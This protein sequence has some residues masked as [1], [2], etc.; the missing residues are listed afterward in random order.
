MAAFHQLIDTLPGSTQRI[1][2]ISC[3]GEMSVTGM[4]RQ[5]SLDLSWFVL[6]LEK[7]LHNEP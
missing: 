2:E 5:L 1:V 6:I 3:H 7:R 4:F